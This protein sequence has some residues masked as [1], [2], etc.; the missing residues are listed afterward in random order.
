MRLPAKGQIEKSGGLKRGKKI[1]VAAVGKSKGIL[2]EK[3]KR[4]GQ[5][6]DLMGSPPSAL[7]P[8]LPSPSTLS[9]EDTWLWNQLNIRKRDFFPLPAKVM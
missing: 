3:K 8:T 7:F 9:K 5:Q 4:L 2:A 6:W 1:I